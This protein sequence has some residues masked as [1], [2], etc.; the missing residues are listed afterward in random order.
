MQI[1]GTIKLIQN[2]EL[3]SVKYQR[4]KFVLTYNERQL[5]YD[6]KELFK[7]QTQHIL[8]HLT[9]S[10]V[11]LLDFFSVGDKVNIEFSIKGRQYKTKEGT[12]FFFNV[13]EVQKVDLIK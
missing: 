11:D 12:T 3:V 1:T 10:R 13:L 8:F 7:T 5:S 4:R 9:Q 6:E 2:I